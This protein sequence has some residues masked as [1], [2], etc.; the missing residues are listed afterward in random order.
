MIEF[1]KLNSDKKK[2][3][4]KRRLVCRFDGQ[5]FEDDEILLHFGEHHTKEFEAWKQSRN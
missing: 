4:K 5:K 1:G 2:S 3:G